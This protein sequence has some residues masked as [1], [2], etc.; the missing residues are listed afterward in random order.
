MKQKPVKLEGKLFEEN[1]TF[2]LN[3]NN[4]EI[5]FLPLEAMQASN[6]ELNPV[7]ELIRDMIDPQPEKRISLESVVKRLENVLSPSATA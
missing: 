3:Q 1:F 4:W 6:H 7:Y 2:F 5:R